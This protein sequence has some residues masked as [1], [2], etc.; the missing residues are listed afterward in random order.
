M[1]AAQGQGQGL[2]AELAACGHRL[3][4]LRRAFPPGEEAWAGAKH[5]LSPPRHRHFAD[6]KLSGLSLGSGCRRPLRRSDL[7]LLPMLE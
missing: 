6:T 3:A 1:Q 4:G 7:K 5:P 2:S